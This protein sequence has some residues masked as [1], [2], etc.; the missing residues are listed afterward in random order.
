MLVTGKRLKSQINGSCLDLQAGGTAI[1][2]VMHQKLPGVTID[3]EIT[4]KEHVHQLCKKISP[5]I[6]LTYLPIGEGEL[7]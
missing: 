5:T 4:F 1:E 6:G 7:F 3:E 2:Q